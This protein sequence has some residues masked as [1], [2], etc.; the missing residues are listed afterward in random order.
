MIFTNN[1]GFL[2]ITMIFTNNHSFL[3]ITT[4]FTNVR[5]FTNAHGYLRMRSYTDIKLLSIACMVIY[6]CAVIYD[7]MFTN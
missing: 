7:R 3:Q 1:H 4:D 6:D 2:Q 5:L